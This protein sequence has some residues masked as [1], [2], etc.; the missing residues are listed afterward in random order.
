MKFNKFPKDYG[1]EAARKKRL[2]QVHQKAKM[3]REYAKICKREGI[4]SSRVNIN[5]KLSLELSS[6]AVNPVLSEKKRTFKKQSAQTTSNSKT[7]LNKLYESATKEKSSTD[8][9]IT[10]QSDKRRSIEV[11]QKR[12]KR[13]GKL[14]SMKNKHGQPLLGLQMK[15]ILSK[16]ESK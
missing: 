8:N 14:R 10:N 11:A 12:R 4:N 1:I 2:Q 5:P 9:K 15:S 3:L 7:D 16:L 6:E 13:E